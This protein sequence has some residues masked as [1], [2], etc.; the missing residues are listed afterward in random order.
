MV[1]APPS[2][3]D[4]DLFDVVEVDPLAASDSRITKDAKS[5][6]VGG[7]S[8]VFRFVGADEYQ[9]IGS[10]IAFDGVVALACGPDKGIIARAKENS[11]VVRATVH[12]IVT[13]AGAELVVAG[14]A[15]EREPDRI[16]GEARGID[17]VVAARA[18]L[19]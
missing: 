12:Q 18:C 8:D 14:T 7:E 3:V 1:S 5:I 17:D 19:R 4:V 15:V 9:A 11:V 10:A 13:A 16:G 6:T 2:V